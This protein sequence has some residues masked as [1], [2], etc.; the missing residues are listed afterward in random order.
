VD[1]RAKL[2]KKRPLPWSERFAPKARTFDP[3]VS[4]AMFT[5]SAQGFRVTKKDREH[6]TSAK[7]EEIS[8]G[9]STCACSDY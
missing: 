8:T 4:L 2:R 9:A 5:S 6:Q 7:L 3:Q 1:I